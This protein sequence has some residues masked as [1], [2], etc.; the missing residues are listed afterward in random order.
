[1]T[2]TNV[3]RPVLSTKDTRHIYSY[4]DVLYELHLRVITEYFSSYQVTVSKLNRYFLV[5]DKDNERCYITIDYSS[6]CQLR[7]QL[8]KE[9]SNGY[10]T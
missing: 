1:M 7:S 6:A 10:Q 4:E 3:V 9:N 8:I 5:Y 2:Q